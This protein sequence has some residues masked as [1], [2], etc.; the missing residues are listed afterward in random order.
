THHLT[1]ARKTPGREPGALHS[2]IVFAGSK[3][4]GFTKIY[5]LKQKRKQH[6][7]PPRHILEFQPMSEKPTIARKMLLSAGGRHGRASSNAQRGRTGKRSGGRW[8]FAAPKACA[9]PT[10]TSRSVVPTIPR[11]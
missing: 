10:R 8:K 2:R 1:I 4:E 3:L 7:R 9:R 11:C 6:R 5:R